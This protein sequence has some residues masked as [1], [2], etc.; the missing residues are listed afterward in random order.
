[1]PQ[2]RWNII[3][4][5]GLMIFNFGLQSQEQ[6]DDELE[7]SMAFRRLHKLVSSTRR[8]K[9]KLIR[10]D[11]SKKHTSKGEESNLSL[12]RSEKMSK[13]FIYIWSPMAS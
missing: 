11:E 10:I 9:K 7:E 4:S 13:I 3:Y 1:M 5:N 2:L 6:S 8:V 12:Q